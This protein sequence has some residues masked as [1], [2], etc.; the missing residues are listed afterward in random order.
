MNDARHLAIARAGAA[1]GRLA[2][3]ADAFDDPLVV[4]AIDVSPNAGPAPDVRP[5]LRFLQARALGYGRANARRYRWGLSHAS[6]PGSAAYRRPPGAP[7]VHWRPL[8]IGEV[9]IARERHGVWP[10]VDGADCAR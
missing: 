7:A 8:E 4:A 2:T 6:E 3:A 1:L 5:Y 9:S 10:S